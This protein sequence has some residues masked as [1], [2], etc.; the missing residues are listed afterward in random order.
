MKRIS[1]TVI[2]LVMLAG[3]CLAQTNASA[4]YFVG[5]TSNI[6]PAVHVG[7]DLGRAW[8][9]GSG[10][11]IAAH[12]QAAMKADSAAAMSS[13][14]AELCKSVWSG[15]AGAVF[16]LIGGGPDFLNTQPDQGT[17]MKAVVGGFLILKC[18]WM[19]PAKG[20]V[21]TYIHDKIGFAACYRYKT[22]FQG[23]TTQ[24]ANGNQFEL[25]L[26]FHR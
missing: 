10:W 13:A 4:Y 16:L 5:A 9:F 2:T 22:N 24:F 7:Y 17:Y 26:T 11:W 6:K 23:T 19:I 18:S 25:A 21:L 1:L 14:D 15:P 3:T 8:C 12:G 20:K